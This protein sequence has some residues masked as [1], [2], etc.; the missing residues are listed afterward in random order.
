MSQPR[1]STPKL[2][3]SA[4]KLP[5]LLGPQRFTGWKTGGGGA[6]GD[7]GS[8]GAGGVGAGGRARCPRC[9]LNSRTC[10]HGTAAVVL[11]KHRA[12]RKDNMESLTVTR[13]RGTWIWRRDPSWLPSPWCSLNYEAWVPMEKGA[14]K[15]GA[16]HECPLVCFVPELWSWPHSVS[17][18]AP[19]H[20]PAE[21]TEAGRGS[22]GPGSRGSEPRGLHSAVLAG[23]RGLS[24]RSSLCGEGPMSLETVLLK[25]SPLRPFPSSGATQWGP[26]S[27]P[28]GSVR[29]S[30]WAPCTVMGTCGV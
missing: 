14:G 17:G 8:G 23:L 22:L 12:F 29:F 4:P 6:N 28:V 30:L 16:G 11:Q 15:W 20:P 5:G 26:N 24:P 25:L 19:T 13:G 21:D 27:R 3:A 2:A 7:G 9:A 10:P 1:D 18:T